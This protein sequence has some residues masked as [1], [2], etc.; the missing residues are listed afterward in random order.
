MFKFYNKKLN[1]KCDLCGDIIKT[2]QLV[3][4]FGVGLVCLQCAVIKD[5]KILSI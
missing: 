1:R 4:L 2:D 3:V 5:N